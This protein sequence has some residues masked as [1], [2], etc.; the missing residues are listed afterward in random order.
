MR[1]ALVAVAAALF[2]R[3]DGPP[4][5]ARLEWLADE[6]HD[7]FAHAGARARFTL[8]ASLLAISILAP[9]YIARLPPFRRLA[10]TDRLHALERF[11]RSMF[12][13]A[14][15]GVKAMACIVWYEHPDTLREI[16]ADVRCLLPLAPASPSSEAAE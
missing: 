5:A 11:E 2:A 3:E 15:L 4:P 6:T 10:H 12:G 7:F 8:R 13:L 16:D 14:V 1:L 9:L